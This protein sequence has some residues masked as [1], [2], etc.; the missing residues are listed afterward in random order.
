MYL[1]IASGMTTPVAGD[2]SSSCERIT[3]SLAAVISTI[4]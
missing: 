3:G 2:K 1:I 4:F